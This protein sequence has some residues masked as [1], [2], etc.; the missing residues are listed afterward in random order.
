[1]I[2]TSPTDHTHRRIAAIGTF[3]GVH[4][5]HRHLIE[6]IRT[7]GLA[8]NLTPS[9]VTFSNHPR[10]IVDPEFRLDMLMSVEDRVKELLKSGIEDVI[11]IKFDSST[12]AMTAREFM[13]KLHR[14]YDV[15]ALVMGFN[16]KFG[17]DKVSDFSHYLTI[18][19]EEGIKIIPADEFTHVASGSSISSSAIRRLLRENKPEEAMRLLGHPYRLSGKVEHGKELGRTIGF[20]TANIVPTD[21]SVLIPADGVYV[22][23]VKLPDGEY[24]R[25]ILNIGHRPT[26]DTPDAPKSIEAHILDYDG[27]LYGA[28]VSVDFLKYLRPERRFSSIA[29]LRSQLEEDAGNARA[30][31]HS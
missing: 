15:D 22:A 16:H 10:Q 11:L 9:V 12:M 27:D 14:D 31:N 28:T 23:N 5:G 18:G 17:H 1:M 7:K 6:T 24:R 3:D 2:I 29:D 19:A 21:H 25:A 20:P 8:L 26:I 30:I 4:P 13:R